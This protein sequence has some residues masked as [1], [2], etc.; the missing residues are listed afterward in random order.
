MIAVEVAVVQIHAAKDADAN[1]MFRKKSQR[2]SK[3]H[4]VRRQGGK[5]YARKKEAQSG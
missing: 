1:P 2:T 4:D 5:L 3:V